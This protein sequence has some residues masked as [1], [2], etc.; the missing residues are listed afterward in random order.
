MN[1]LLT[2]QACLDY[3]AKYRQE[4]VTKYDFYLKS[5]IGEPIEQ[6]C[7]ASLQQ[8]FQDDSLEVLGVGKDIKTALQN[9]VLQLQMPSNQHFKTVDYT[10]PEWNHDNH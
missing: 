8:N 10:L 2:E 7:F 6:S 9:L 4:S 5:F 1:P 3:I